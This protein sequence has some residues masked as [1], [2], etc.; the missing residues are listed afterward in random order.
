M[1]AYMSDRE[2]RK[3]ADFN[4]LD[5]CGCC[6]ADLG[7]SLTYPW[8]LEDEDCR[9]IRQPITAESEARAILAEIGEDDGSYE[10]TWPADLIGTASLDVQEC[11]AA[12]AES[13]RRFVEGA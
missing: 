6:E 3:R 2:A 13:L 4:A 8:H 11:A 1:K 10:L 5:S 7:P 9:V 12:L